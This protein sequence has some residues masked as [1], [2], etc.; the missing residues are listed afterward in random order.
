MASQLQ[1]FERDGCRLAACHRFVIMFALHHGVAED[2]L[3]R[4][5]AADSRRS[6]L[7]THGLRG[8]TSPSC[9]SC[10]MRVL[11]EHAAATQPLL[12]R[13]MLGAASILLAGCKCWPWQLKST[14]ET[15]TCWKTNLVVQSAGAFVARCL[16]DD[17]HTWEG[18]C[19][20]ELQS[21]TKFR[22]QPGQPSLHAR[23]GT[24]DSN[25]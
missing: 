22:R 11:K 20:D 16:I 15:P 10:P 19:D 18:L 7:A 8:E 12:E 6:A 14:H 1:D 23:P 25:T 3:S 2:E 24:N 17:L 9:C 5:R 21:W 4:W 13:R